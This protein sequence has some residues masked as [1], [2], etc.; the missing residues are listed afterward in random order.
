MRTRLK[1]NMLRPHERILK[2]AGVCLLRYWFAKG[3][4]VPLSGCC[5]SVSSHLIVCPLFS[6]PR[7]VRA[8]FLALSCPCLPPSHSGRQ[9]LDCLVV[10][11]R[12][13]GRQ[14]VPVV[15]MKL[16][17]LEEEGPGQH[18]LRGAQHFVACNRQQ[19]GH[20]LRQLLFQ[21]PA[22][23]LQLSRKGEPGQKLGAYQSYPIATS[24]S[25]GK[26]DEDTVPISLWLQS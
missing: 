16:N 1:R 23:A 6:F 13:G 21:Q 10:V 17:D 4:S 12:D 14:G 5:S 9:F 7:K 15:G 19:L 3:P 25:T 2:H 26:V 20:H 11:L 8:V 18:G 22:G 24:I